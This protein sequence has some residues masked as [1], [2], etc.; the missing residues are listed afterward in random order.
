[1][2]NYA[3]R[4]WNMPKSKADRWRLRAGIILL[5]SNGFFILVS[6]GFVFWLG[7]VVGAVLT[8]M[9]LV[10]ILRAAT[11]RMN[12]RYKPY[13][14][15]RVTRWIVGWFVLGIV[16]LVFAIWNIIMDDSGSDQDSDATGMWDMPNATIDDVWES[17]P[18]RYYDQDAPSFK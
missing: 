16:F 10:K 17:D 14:S 3:G 18:T 13:K 12:E 8:F 7:L 5:A 15:Y 4:L 2:T 6:E 9:G 11:D 1:M